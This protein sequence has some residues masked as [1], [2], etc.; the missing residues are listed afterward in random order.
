MD[1]TYHSVISRVMKYKFNICVP[2]PDTQEATQFPTGIVICPVCRGYEANVC[3]FCL[4]AGEVSEE[5]LIDYKE[6]T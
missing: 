3:T 2:V 1:K 4:G 6:P 5:S